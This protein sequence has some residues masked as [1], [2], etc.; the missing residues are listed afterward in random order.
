MTSM[1]GFS[2]LI[3]IGYSYCNDVSWQEVNLFTNTAFEQAVLVHI[4]NDKN[5]GTKLKEETN[6][7][8]NHEIRYGVKSGVKSEKFS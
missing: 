5:M 4:F 8:T 1:S 2:I 7:S 3:L 6:I